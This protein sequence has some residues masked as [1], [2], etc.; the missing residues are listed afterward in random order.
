[1]LTCLAWS[2]HSNICLQE[3]WSEPGLLENSTLATHGLEVLK[4]ATLMWH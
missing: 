3:E 4:Y 1:M 2:D